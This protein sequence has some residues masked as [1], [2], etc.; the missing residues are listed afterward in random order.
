MTETIYIL[1]MALVIAIG[2]F[3]LKKNDRTCEMHQ[4]V[5]HAIYLYNVDMIEKGLDD[6]L[7]QEECMEPYDKTLFRLFDWGY[8]NIVSPEVLE[9]IRLYIEEED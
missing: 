8:E 1:L 7:D 9:K 2:F 3:F 4:L 5:N 6:R